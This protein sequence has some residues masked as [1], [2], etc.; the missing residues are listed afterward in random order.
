MTSRRSLVAIVVLAASFTSTAARAQGFQK[1]AYVDLQRALTEIEE[2]KAAKNRLKKKFDEKQKLLDTKQEEL[3]REEE[4]LEKSGQ[5]MAPEKK[6]EKM[7]E[8]KQ[9]VMEVTNFWQKAQKELSDEERVVT[10][11]IFGKMNSIIG[12]I[13]EADGITMVFEK[14]SG[15]LYAPPSMDLTNELVR[16][17][18]AKYGGAPGKDAKSDAKAPKDAPKK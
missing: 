7:S 10:Q 4:N 9:R 6:N 1:I 2:G 18:N 12:G 16:K 11:E 13:A 8:L 3:K 17:Y 15:L 14:N 5:V